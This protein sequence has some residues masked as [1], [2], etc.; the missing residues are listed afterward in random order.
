MSLRRR[1]SSVLSVSVLLVACRDPTQVTIELTTDISCADRPKTGISVGPLG[2]LET[3][4]L[5]TETDRCTPGTGRIGS[6]VVLPKDDRKSQFAVR[7]IA[8][9]NRS[10]AECIEMGYTG[11]CVV[12]RRVLGFV[13]HESLYLPIRLE[14]SCVDV[15]CDATETCRSGSCVPAEIDDPASCKPPDGCDV[16]VPQFAGSGGSGGFGGAP[17]TGGT[18][19]NGGTSAGG[20]AGASGGAGTGGAAGSPD[21]GAAG[22]SDDGAAG[23][24]PELGPFGP[25]VPIAAL[26]S[27]AMDS[28]PSFP[29]D[30]L[31]L[32]FSSTRGLGNAATDIW[33]SRR[34][35]PSEPWPAP[36]R[37]EE[38]CSPHK[39]STPKVSADGLTLW[40]S[41]DRPGCVGMLD[42][43][44]S[45]RPTRADRWSPPRCVREL[46][47][48]WADSTAAADPSLLNL[49][50][51]SERPGSQ[52]SD[53]Y[54]STRATPTEPWS[55]PV[56]LP[57]VNSYEDD[58]DGQLVANGS[59]LY[60]SSSG[61]GTAGTSTSADLFVA[62]RASTNEPFG[63]VT[64]LTEL[65]SDKIDTDP[66][67][68]QDERYIVFTSSRG[69][70][71]TLYEAW[72]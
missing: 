14:A 16:E 3:R 56:L 60:F 45:T 38:L 26:M 27:D 68:S 72:R 29:E 10:A 36:E 12:A 13:P 34:A 18:D 21:D 53:L 46:S 55:A 19:S 2:E 23:A 54:W 20:Q 17:S 5:S 25:P 9:L 22:S 28:N 32:Y 48:P 1:A 59:K 7:V 52:N 66:W 62:S 69:T 4:P 35:S 43:W 65:N 51:T 24:P 49:V 40:L 15:P 8:G 33:V 61:Y 31:E 64:P 39:D 67:V 11:G 44:V 57:G 41:S 63:A 50:F 47:S 37:V 70:S 58:E 6:I 42:I 71:M 30:R